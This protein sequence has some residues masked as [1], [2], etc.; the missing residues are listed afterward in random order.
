MKDKTHYISTAK[1][2]EESTL[3][4]AIGLNRSS[5]TISKT[6]QEMSVGSNKI[7][8]RFHEDSSLSDGEALESRRFRGIRPPAEPHRERRLP[9]ARGRGVE[10]ET[11]ENEHT[12]THMVPQ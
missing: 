12:W 4:Q 2:L 8:A 11:L 6:I 1:M 10:S 9:R 5:A 3:F 7:K